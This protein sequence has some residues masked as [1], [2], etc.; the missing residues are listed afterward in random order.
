MATTVPHIPETAP[1]TSEQR[2][3]LNGYLAALFAAEPQPATS[4]SRVNSLRVAVYFATQ[5]GTSERLAKKLAKALKAQGHAAEIASLEKATPDEIASQ[6]HAV[7]L[8]STY[9]EGDPPDGVKPLRDR[10]FSDAAPALPGLRYSVF[11]LGDKNYEHF[12]KFGIELDE[13]LEQLGAARIA[14]RVECDVDVDAPFES[15][16][17]D[18]LPRLSSDLPEGAGS[19]VMVSH[20]YGP[21]GSTQS[22][23]PT[24][25][26]ENPYRAELKERCAL[27]AEASSKLTV[28]LGLGVEDPQFRYEAGDACGV[29]A[30]NDPALVQQ[31]LARL[32]FGNDTVVNL[33]RVGECTIQDALLHH[34]QPSRTT[35]KTVQAFAEKTGSKALSALLPAAQGAHLEAFLH[36][37]DLLDM[38]DDFPGTITAAEELVACVPRLAPRLYSI[39]SSPAAHR[40]ELHCTISVVRYRSHNRERGGVASTMLGERIR[41]GTKVPVYIQPNKRFRLPV[42]TATPMLMIGPG[43]GVAPF[44]SFLH[45]RLALGHT[46]RNWLFFGERSASTDFLYRS[47]LESMRDTGHLT[48]LDLAFSRDQAHKIYVQD[49]MIEQGSRIWAWLQDGAQFY[50]CGDASRMAKD[51]DAALHRVIETH[52]RM[53]TDR[54]AEYVSQLQEQSRYHRDVY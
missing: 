19:S 24:Y 30:Q 8:A 21:T 1:F 47:E 38:L 4:D 49:R 15:W 26:R 45:E 51:V 14:P 44:R 54:A 6:Q 36:G 7:F 31:I 39:A 20:S 53:S 43:T 40:G 34:L 41:L 12:C 33:Q 17:K 25:T 18:L 11:C 16:Q 37:R 22:T 52:G 42:D 5:S 23:V 28:H 46:G 35:R 48:H 50:I 9:G 27:T 29:L 32:P 2:A 13:R 10:L 3:W